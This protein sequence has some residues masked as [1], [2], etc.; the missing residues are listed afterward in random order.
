MTERR[1]KM[2]SA[3]VLARQ[4]H[5]HAF[6]DSARLVDQLGV[7]A[8]ID[9]IGNTI[10]SL[11]VL[12]GIAAS[13]ALCGAEVG[14][15]V[16]ENHADAVKLLRQATPGKSSAAQLQ[17]LLDAK[18][19]SQYSPRLVTVA[20]ALELTEQATRLVDEMDAVI[21]RRLPGAAPA[22]WA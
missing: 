5:A 14:E 18:A 15:R 13:D 19:E 2:N 8:G 1:K 20:R 7:D 4:S 22:D 10:A 12:A 17:R 16:G 9:P 21:R 3:D 11:A 6:L